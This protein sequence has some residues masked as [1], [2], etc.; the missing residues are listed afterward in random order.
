MRTQ[1]LV[2]GAWVDGTPAA[3][4][5]YR[6]EV[7]AGVWPEQRNVAPPQHFD[8]FTTDSESVTIN[9]DPTAGFQSVYFGVNGD[10]VSMSFDIVDGQGV[11]QTQLDSTSLGYPLVLALPVIKV[12]NGVTVD[13]VYF[14]TELNGG[15]ITVVGSFPASGNWKM[16][17]ARINAALAEIGAA[18]AIDKPDVTFRVNS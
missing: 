8:I 3:G 2:D 1:I 5:W 15:V 4:E 9:G 11:L 14:A 12:A 16:T 13:E 7:L 10:P 17:T 18:W 6:K